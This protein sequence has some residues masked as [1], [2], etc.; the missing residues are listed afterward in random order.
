MPATSEGTGVALPLENRAVYVGDLPVDLEHPEEA[1]Q[2]LFNTIGPVVSVK[3]CRDSATH[4]SR[5][6]AFVNY[7]SAEDANRAVATL[8]FTE[9]VPGQRLRVTNSR[10]DAAS[11]KLGLNNVFVKKIEASVTSA[12]LAVA[13][14]AIGTVVSCK[15]ATDNTGRSLGYGFVAFEDEAMVASA[16]REM[17][18]TMLRDQAIL[19]EPFKRASERRAEQVQ[20][21]VTVY[22]NNLK[23]HVT[24]DDVRRAVAEVAEP[25]EVF[26]ALSHAHGTSFALV[27][28]NSNEDA[29]AV[30]A[31]FN[32]E[33]PPMLCES[34]SEPLLAC[35][36]MNRAERR[37][38][39]GRAVTADVYADRAQTVYVKH[40]DECTTESQLRELFSRYG[41]IKSLT[42][43]TDVTGASRGFA[44]VSYSDRG[45]AENAIRNLHGA[46]RFSKH[47][48]HVCHWHPREHRT[49][50]QHMGGRVVRATLRG[51]E[52]G[53]GGPR[54]RG[55]GMAMHSVDQTAMPAGR[56][57]HT[58][59]HVQGA[60]V[61]A[62]YGHGMAPS[63]MESMPFSGGH[64]TSNVG[65]GLMYAHTSAV[66]VVP[67]SVPGGQRGGMPLSHGPRG[68]HTVMHSHAP[69]Q[70]GVL[71]S[72]LAYSPQGMMGNVM[73]H[74]SA[75]G[76]VAVSGATS[77]MSLP[78]PPQRVE[79]P[80]TASAA[81]AVVG[82]HGVGAA[83]TPSSVAMPR[84]SM[85]AAPLSASKLAELPL[86][87]QKNALGERLYP[88][89]QAINGLQ[90]PKITGMLLELDTS[91]LLALLNE[92]SRLNTKVQEA[93]MVLRRHTDQ[94]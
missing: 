82:M 9:I 94:H 8:S 23:P 11:R 71:T 88:L 73:V 75:G 1:L 40:I 4:A 74:P 20:S 64:V 58:T 41:A 47:A 36:A 21:F 35:R 43:A 44:F 16:I 2:T 18:G 72:S 29:V 38:E 19:V 65:S 62:P 7:Q 28:M 61:L 56:G 49:E 89:V 27:T 92:P 12:E 46:T 34:T 67:G 33:R 32:G 15:V 70:S 5:G 93:V 86:S 66:P 55:G 69:L 85:P 57:A 52:R 53:V 37:A 51:A 24:E 10:R 90:A 50:L 31:R 84:T 91:E 48:L 59:T 80:R 81:T 25:K 14:G 22:M 30:I 87:E 77:G 60:A 76:S 3:V 54:G 83:S 39:R 78:G 17:N 45:A 6:Y 42:I 79:I 26:V 13:F 63:A 68:A